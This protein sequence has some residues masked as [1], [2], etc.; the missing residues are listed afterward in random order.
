LTLREEGRVSTGEV[1]RKGREG[2]HIHQDYVVLVFLDLFDALSTVVDGEDEELWGGKEWVK[3]A[4]RGKERM[5]D[6]PSSSS[7]SSWLSPESTHY[8]PP[9]T[10]SRSPGSYFEPLARLPVRG[11]KRTKRSTRY[12]NRR[13]EWQGWEERWAEGALWK[14]VQWWS[15]GSRGQLRER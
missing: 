7:T 10:P 2:T 6:A 5:E 15:Y 11:K 14:E 13:R 3:L 4:E 12:E 1:G 8:P 9:T